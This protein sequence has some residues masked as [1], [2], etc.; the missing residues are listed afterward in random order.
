MAN[1]TLKCTGCKQYFPREQM[2]KLPAGNFHSIEC[3]AEYSAKKAR[4]K[5]NTAKKKQIQERRKAVREKKKALK[6]IPKLTDEAQSAVN[7]YVRL[8]DYYRPCISCGK[9]NL[10]VE[11]EQGY[12]HGGVWDAGHYRS[13]GAAQQL[14]FNL[15]N[16]HKQCKSCNGGEK[17][18]VAKGVS[19]RSAYRKNLI[20]KID[21]DAVLEL[22]A[23]NELAGYNREYL[24]RIARIFRKKVRILEKRLHL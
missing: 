1:S 21:L 16:I 20:E 12:K 24:E 18:N 4:R 11:Q 5:I 19:V 3:A 14:R 13:R 8:R 15:K 10:E 23:N 22:E 17:L 2:L 9:S 6:T 7:K